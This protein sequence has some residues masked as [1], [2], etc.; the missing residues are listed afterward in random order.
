MTLSLFYL[1][2]RTYNLEYMSSCLVLLHKVFPGH[3]IDW[4]HSDFNI[5]ALLNKIEWTKKPHHHDRILHYGF[6]YLFLNHKFLLP[7]TD[8]AH[9]AW[10]PQNF[11]NSLSCTLK[12]TSH[13]IAP[14]IQLDMHIAPPR[15]PESQCLALPK[16]KWH[17]WGIL[18]LKE[19][20]MILG[21]IPEKKSWQN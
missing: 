11:V 17:Y 18:G 10:R 5:H 1:K 2:L 4:S 19:Q 21:N 6:A 16:P 15:G 14:G 12:H 9:I 7:C 3:Y 20:N 8:T 13:R